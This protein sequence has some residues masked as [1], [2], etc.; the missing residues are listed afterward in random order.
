MHCDGYTCESDRRDP[1]WLYIFIRSLG[2]CAPSSLV[3]ERQQQQHSSEHYKFYTHFFFFLGFNFSSDCFSF[4]YTCAFFSEHRGNA[5]KSAP[6]S[7]A[8]TA[9][10]NFKCH[11][12]S[13]EFDIRFV[14]SLVSAI[15]YKSS[16]FHFSLQFLRSRKF[17]QNCVFCFRIKLKVCFYKIR[18]LRRKNQCNVIFFINSM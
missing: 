1:F 11:C 5:G 15:S 6:L 2:R 12:T 17:L 18:R 8:K 14:S 9:I 7:I 4:H 16:F 13:A 10:L 3:R